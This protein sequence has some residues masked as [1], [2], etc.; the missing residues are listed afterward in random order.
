MVMYTSRKTAL[1]QLRRRRPEINRWSQ[2]LIDEY[3]KE[4][5][6]RKIIVEAWGGNLTYIPKEFIDANLCARAIICGRSGSSIPDEMWT[7]K[8]ALAAV[9]FDSDAIRSIPARFKTLEFMSAWILRNPSIIC[10]WDFPK[11]HQQE[12]AIHGAKS[13]A[14]GPLPSYLG[15]SPGFSKEHHEKL[16]AFISEI[17]S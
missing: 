15:R 14:D 5:D 6:Y 8:M 10:A 1:E 3:T 17:A 4:E 13:F 11:E 12:I 7:E 2:D 16:E 9:D